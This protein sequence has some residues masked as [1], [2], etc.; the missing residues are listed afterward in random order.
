[1]RCLILPNSSYQQYVAKI[2]TQRCQQIQADRDKIVHD[3]NTRIEALE[4]QNQ[5]LR[6]HALLVTITHQGA[7]LDAERQA[8]D[9]KHVE[10]GQQYQKKCA[11]LQQIQTMY[12][13]LKQ[14]VQLGQMS[15]VANQD[16]DNTLQSISA[17]PATWAAQ[18]GTA[19]SQEVNDSGL[20]CTAGRTSRHFA[21]A[22]AARKLIHPHQRSGSSAANSA[23]DQQ[24]MP[25]PQ[26][27]RA[28][29]SRE[30]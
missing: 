13:R 26:L 24:K 5:G 22:Q 2:L 28:S 17:Q 16:V 30:L 18:N 20:Y 4:T 23:V 9:Q 6:H 12:D 8:L 11:K 21:S 27:N 15:A 14:K 19:I 7:E 25:P 3:A 29:R 1:V 10:L